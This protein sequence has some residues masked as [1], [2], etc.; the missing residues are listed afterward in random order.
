[1]STL[2]C[3]FAYIGKSI[4]F[5]SKLIFIAVGVLLIALGNY[6]KVIQLFYW[7]QNTLDLESKEVWKLTHTG[8]ETLDCRRIVNCIGKFDNR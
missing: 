8:W 1:M 5:K 2:A 4:H 7:N 3:Y 6:F